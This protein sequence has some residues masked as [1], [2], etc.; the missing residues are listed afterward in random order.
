MIQHPDTQPRT[1]SGR[2]IVGIIFVLVALFAVGVVLL[3]P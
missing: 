1:V 2:V 3:Q